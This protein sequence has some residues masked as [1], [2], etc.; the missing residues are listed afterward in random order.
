MMFL[1]KQHSQTKEMS[2]LMEPKGNQVVENSVQELARIYQPTNIRK[3]VK[4]YIK[5]YCIPGGYEEALVHLVEVQM[6]NLKHP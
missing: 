3:F 5:K 6:Q 4:E 1:R 2:C